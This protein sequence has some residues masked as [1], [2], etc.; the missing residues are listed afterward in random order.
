MFKCTDKEWTRFVEE[1]LVEVEE[2][3]TKYDFKKMCKKFGLAYLH[4]LEI[5]YKI[6]DTMTD[7]EFRKINGNIPSKFKL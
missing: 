6:K 7:E 5:T 3:N 4:Y 2:S 1:G